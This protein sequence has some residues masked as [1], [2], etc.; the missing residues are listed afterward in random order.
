[1]ETIGVIGLGKMGQGLAKNLE[2]NGYEVKGFDL[3]KEVYK[4]FEKLNFSGF[5]QIEDL[6]SSMQKPRKILM[7]VNAGEP[8]EIVFKKLVSILEQGDVIVDCGNAKY[9]DSIRRGSEAKEKNIHFI[10]AGI[11]GGPKGAL[12]GCCAMVGATKEAFALVE[13]MFDK[14]TIE[15]GYLHTGNIGSGH[16]AKM[17]HNGIEYG[18]MQAIAEG[19]QVMEK[20]GFDYNLEDIS[21]IW[22]N[23]SVIRSWLIELM[24]E[25]YKQDPK[26]DSYT[27]VMQ[28]NGEGLWTVE[29]AFKQGTPAP[30]I[31]LSVM[32]RQ[33]SMQDESYAGKVVAALRNKFGGHAVVKK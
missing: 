33:N 23:G 9:S 2:R 11:S 21:K 4:E 29:E 22:N 15:N 30:V 28:M 7:V 20:S 3:N 18:M 13:Q 31:A 25:I 8:T 26:L 24:E 5:E 12:L 32:M 17:V 10:D 1:M 16:F 14:I 19:Y 6:V 27:D